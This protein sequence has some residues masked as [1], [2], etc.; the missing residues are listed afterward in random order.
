M[1]TDVLTV[2]TDWLKHARAC[3][4]LRMQLVLADDQQAEGGGGTT[5]RARVHRKGGFS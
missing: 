3:S 1:S 2:L 4:T 5:S